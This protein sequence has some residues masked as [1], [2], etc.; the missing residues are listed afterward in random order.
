RA[1][2][3]RATPLGAVTPVG[4]AS[5]DPSAARQVAITPNFFRLFGVLPAR[6][7]AFTNEDAQRGA[8]PVAVVSTEVWTRHFG[9]AALS[10]QKL[11][12]DGDAVTVVGVLP[13]TFQV[14]ERSDI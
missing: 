7:R 9:D 14:L 5:A 10:G 6:G 4:D 11:Y 3:D 8:P 1:H 12:I 13:R 2:L